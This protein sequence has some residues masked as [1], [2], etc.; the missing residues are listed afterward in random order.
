MKTT[1]LA[2]VATSLVALSL[3]SVAQ[4][5]DVYVHTTG[6]S[7]TLE[8]ETRDGWSPV[9]TSPC[10]TLL[11]RSGVYRANAAG[12]RASRSFALRDQTLRL[13]AA[14]SAP[15]VV[16]EVL[17]GAG[18]VM[19][20]GAITYLVV[21]KPSLYGSDFSW[22]VSGGVIVGGIVFAILGGVIL[23]ASP[24]S[25]AWFTGEALTW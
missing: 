6:D 16:G 1:H 3:T 18:G 14:S 24:R 21:G 7:M 5:D 4:A 10:D 20:A 25:K 22:D 8:I 11:P 17:L 9:C 13:E 2:A 19:I 15:L 12:A 23:A